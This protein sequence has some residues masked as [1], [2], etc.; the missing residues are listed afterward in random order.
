M[1]KNV[2]IIC[3]VTLAILLAAIGLFLYNQKPQDLAKVSD[4]QIISLLNKNSDAKEYIQN[5]SDF[6]I[7]NK[8]ILTKESI[9]AGRNGASF[10]EVY[11]GLELQ[12]N[13][14]VLVNLINSTGDKGLIAAVD[15]E[16][17]T[18]PVAYGLLLLK[19][20]GQTTGTTTNK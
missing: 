8:T 4:S 11:Q 18:A 9:M 1:K 17:K 3:V 12:D 10:R 13:R 16:T 5:H 15:F 19:A 6:K 14:Y 7:Q 2:L 20:N